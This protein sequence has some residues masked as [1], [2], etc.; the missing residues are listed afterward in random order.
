MI[1][2]YLLP[3]KNIKNF[4]WTTRHLK[5]TNPPFPPQPELHSFIIQLYEKQGQEPQT[6][7]T[8]SK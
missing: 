6:T 1:F 2:R 3:K 4:K 5:K 7:T 8:D